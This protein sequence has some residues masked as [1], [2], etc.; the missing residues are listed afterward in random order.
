MS[1]TEL[2]IRVIGDSVLRKKAK[3]VSRVT[4]EL[5]DFLSKMSRF[6]YDSKGIGLAAPQVGLGQ[7]LIVVDIGTGLYKLVNPRIVKKSGSQSNE[8]GCLSCP[9]IYIMVRRA[10]NICV[11]ALDENGKLQKID[12]HDLLACAIQHEIDH[13]DGK[14]I[15]DYASLLK[16]IALKKKLANLANEKLLRSE[17]KHS[18]L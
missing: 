16:K 11:E 13:L 9:G 1:E 17:D 15:V 3:K 7:R 2:K 8:E 14:L 4:G 12:A 5:S 10:K 18:K 6:M